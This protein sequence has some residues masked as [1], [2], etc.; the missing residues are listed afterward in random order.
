M[1][2]VQGSAT[3]IG[4]HHHSFCRMGVVRQGTTAML[5][6]PILSDTILVVDQNDG[7][8]WRAPWLQVGSPFWV[9]ANWVLSSTVRF[10]KDEIQDA[11]PQQLLLTDALRFRRRVRREIL[12]LVFDF[13]RYGRRW[14]N[15]AQEALADMECSEADR[16]RVLQYTSQGQRFR[17]DLLRLLLIGFTRDD[18]FPP[19]SDIVA[20]T[21]EVWG[22]GSSEASL[23][24]TT[25]VLI[26]DSDPRG[27]PV[28]YLAYSHALP[29]DSSD[30]LLS[31]WRREGDDLV[32]VL[33]PDIA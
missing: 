10:L 25:E 18:A 17:A 16:S 12:D 7:L 28:Y 22:L 5:R 1:L 24:T 23:D 4:R 3:S 13:D 20:D 8:K 15:R 27:T 33:A 31:R 26:L 19:R 29:G 2:A 6:D 14:L 32:R 11:D 21:L 9:E 30:L